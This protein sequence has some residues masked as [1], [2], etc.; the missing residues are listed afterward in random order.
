MTLLIKNSRYAFLIRLDLMFSMSL[1]QTNLIFH[2]AGE[3]WKK[4]GTG[5]CNKNKNIRNF[6]KL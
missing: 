4:V 3:T 6:Y 1:G 5:R 2:F